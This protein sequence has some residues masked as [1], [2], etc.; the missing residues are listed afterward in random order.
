MFHSYVKNY[1]RVHVY[2]TH[3]RFLWNHRH[4]FLKRAGS[5]ALRI[6]SSRA[7]GCQCLDHSDGGFTKHNGTLTMKHWRNGDFKPPGIIYIYY[8]LWGFKQQMGISW[9]EWDIYIYKYHPTRDRASR[10]EFVEASCT[11]KDQC[12]CGRKN[13]TNNYDSW[14]CLNFRYTHYTPFS[15]TNRTTSEV[16]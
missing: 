6:F 11:G 15:I 8:L 12:A 3:F 1:Q 9:G 10:S 4:F 5:A 14:F 2:F 7:A 13:I 16:K